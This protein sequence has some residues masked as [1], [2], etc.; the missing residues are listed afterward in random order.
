MGQAQSFGILNKGAGL[1]P[2]GFTRQATSARLAGGVIQGRINSSPSSCCISHFKPQLA[3]LFFIQHLKCTYWIKGILCGYAIRSGRHPSGSQ[4]LGPTCGW[5]GG[6]WLPFGM[7]AWPYRVTTKYSY[8]M[9]ARPEYTCH[10]LQPLP[11]FPAVDVSL[12]E[13]TR[14]WCYDARLESAG[15]LAW[16]GWGMLDHWGCPV[17]GVGCWQ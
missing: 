9:P 12:L 7:S 16:L 11:S 6:R 8:F 14:R 1:R 13:I 10:I 5:P 2:L 17:R 3:Q 15:D 4:W